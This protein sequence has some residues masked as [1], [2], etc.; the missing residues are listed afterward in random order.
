MKADLRYFY[1]RMIP[2]ALQEAKEILAERC[3]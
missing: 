3:G 2:Y 1:L